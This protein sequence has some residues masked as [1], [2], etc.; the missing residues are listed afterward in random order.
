MAFRIED[1]KL[2]LEDV[3]RGTILSYSY[4]EDLKK[5]REALD[6]WRHFSP[7]TPERKD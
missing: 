7:A 3:E 4:Q 5:E 1:I 2:E 6:F